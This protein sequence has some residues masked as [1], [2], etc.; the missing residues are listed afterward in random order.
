MLPPAR[1]RCSALVASAAFLA[2]LAL[3][4]MNRVAHADAVDDYLQGQMRK[5]HIPGLS[6]AIVR[7]G[8][9]I[10][11]RGYGFADLE[12]SAPATKAS[13]YE[14]GSMSKQF[15]AAAVMMLAEQ[16]RLSLED[17]VTKYFPQAPAAWSSITVQH[18]LSHTSGI[19][20]HVAVPGYLARFRT[21]LFFETSPSRDELLQ[22][23]FELPLE[24][25]PGETWA[26]DNTGY[27]LL[28]SIIEKAGGKD[29]WQFIDERIFKPLGM[30]STASTDPQSL[31]PGRASGYQW[32][33]DSFQ[34]RPALPPAVGFSAGSVVSTVEDL[35]KWSVALDSRKLLS[36]ASYERMWTPFK[37]RDA[38]LPPV[39]Y[40]FGWFIDIYHGHRILQHSGGTPGFSSCIYRFIDDGLTVI[41]LTNHAD[42]IL[43]Q[44]ALDVAGM[45]VPALRRPHQKADPDPVMTRKLRAT[46]G[47]LLKGQYEEAAFTTPMRTFLKTAT[48]QG[49]WQW[50]ASHGELRSL[51]FSDVEQTGTGRVVR[52]LV[53]LNDDAYWLTANMTDDGKIAQLY[54][55]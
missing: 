14:I 19:Q 24:F 42:R 12:L 45:Y 17:P 36:G 33:A 30:T 44:I 49:F 4:L 35:A 9:V 37:T 6:I 32:I 54:W 40:G 43:D 34:N 50:F 55:W 46:L 13:V 48:G 11:A 20:N 27:H 25:P 1:E 2:L 29:F 51:T 39:N 5:L 38:G 23:F 22:M 15:T 18:L 10:K 28:G 31:V 26:Y 7:D 53:H 41:L 47:S 52:Y 8:R 16:G 3:S 21:N